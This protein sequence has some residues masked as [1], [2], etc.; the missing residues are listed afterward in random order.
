MQSNSEQPGSSSQSLAIFKLIVAGDSGVGKSTFIE[1]L[2]AGIL[3]E[4]QLHGKT[5]K[6]HKVKFSTTIG[7]IQFNIWDLDQ[8]SIENEPPNEFFMGADCAII[9]FDV[10]KRMSYKNCAAWYNKIREFNDHAN[11]PIGLT[12][13][14]VDSKEREVKPKM[15]IFH[16]KKN[17]HYEDISALANYQIEKPF[18]HLIR[19]LTQ[20]KG[21][22]LVEAP[23]MKPPEI[24]ME[25]KFV[26]ELES[27]RQDHEVP[28]DNDE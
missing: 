11:I 6:I 14:K 3:E 19:K 13:N 7:E 5:I 22:Y 15:I 8:A 26:K 4:L 20:D 21:L 1:R 23:A 2:S 28:D 24:G 9:M 25:G 17:L 18:I 27:E 12:G 16:R 10:I